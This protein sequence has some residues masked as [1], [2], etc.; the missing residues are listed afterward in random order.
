MK[1]QVGEAVLLKVSPWKGLTK[2][3]KKGKLAPRYIGPFEI[4]NRVG[5]VAYELALPPQYQHVHNVFH[6]SLLKKYN[7]DVNHVIEFEPI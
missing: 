3:G 7:P 6:V 5:E 1:F 4:L 2:F